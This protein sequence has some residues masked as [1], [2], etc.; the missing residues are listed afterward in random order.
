MGFGDL[1][2]LFLFLF[3]QEEDAHFS[4]RRGLDGSKKKSGSGSR[5]QMGESKDVNIGYN[6]SA[7]LDVSE[8]FDPVG[9]CESDLLDILTATLDNETVE[10]EDYTLLLNGLQA[11]FCNGA[12]NA[13]ANATGFIHGEGEFFAKR[14]G[15]N[16]AVKQIRLNAGLSTST[17]A[18]ANVKVTESANA[19][20]ESRAYAYRSAGPNGYSCGRR[21]ATGSLRYYLCTTATGEANS[22]AV[23]SANAT[24][25]GSAVA[26]NAISSDVFVYVDASNIKE[27]NATLSTSATSFA[28]TDASAAA[29][30]YTAAYARALAYV[31]THANVE[32]YYSCLY[33]R[34]VRTYCH[35]G[36][37]GCSYHCHY[38]S[39]CV[40]GWRSIDSSNFQYLVSQVQSTVEQSF[41]SAFASSLAMISVKVNIPAYYKHE[42]GGD[43]TF[44]FPEGIDDIAIEFTSQ[45][46]SSTAE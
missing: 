9:W 46:L 41:A 44:I 1:T 22:T 10:Q 36:C 20:A 39:V 19:T 30:V 18:L 34:Q 16:G 31:A 5:S 27:F 33:T 43:D 42:R 3:E 12:T 6:I 40:G 26:G 21:Y 14:H 15:K 38:R 45:C 11:Y 17:L 32:K 29:Q 28:A 25:H 37:W 23:A 4:L 24:G 7:T 35:Y 8:C 2:R 13:F